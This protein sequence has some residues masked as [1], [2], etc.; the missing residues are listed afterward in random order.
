MV[1]KSVHP[2][3]ERCVGVDSPLIA[4]VVRK[5]LVAGSFNEGPSDAFETL[6]RFVRVFLSCLNILS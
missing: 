1:R 3:K 5:S 6:N 4:I 2:E